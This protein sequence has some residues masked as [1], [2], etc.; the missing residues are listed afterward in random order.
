MPIFDIVFTR[1][2]KMRIKA[3][4]ADAIL[5]ALDNDPCMIPE[6]A[7]NSE[8][9]WDV[10]V[11]KRL[12]QAKPLETLGLLRDDAGDFFV[13]EQEYNE[14][15]ALCAQ[16]HADPKQVELFTAPVSLAGDRKA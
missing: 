16:T 11:L 12:G 2:F 4:S 13:S 15:T 6:W 8:V 5:V 9:D 10:Q 7:D 14:A 1:R 3:A